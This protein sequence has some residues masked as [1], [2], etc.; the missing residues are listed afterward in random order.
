[1]TDYVSAGISNLFVGYCKGFHL[2]EEAVFCVC[3]CVWVCAYLRPWE[4]WLYKPQLAPVMPW[5]LPVMKDGSTRP[6]SG[7]SEVIPLRT[8]THPAIV[9]SLGYMIHPFSLEVF[10]VFYH[11]QHRERHYKATRE[12]LFWRKTSI[13]PLWILVTPSK[14]IITGECVCS[15]V[16]VFSHLMQSALQ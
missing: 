10:I 6:E 14:K 16:C 12:A 1:M 9:P 13:H 8:N 2:I 7:H 15:K 11:R 5:S 3:V 4:G